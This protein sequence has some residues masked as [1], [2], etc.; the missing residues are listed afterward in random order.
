MP[1]L[2]VAGWVKR[3]PTGLIGSNKP[4]GTETAAAMIEDLPRLAP[5]PPAPKPPIDALL[6]E[7]GLR[8][9]DFAGWKR[10]DQIEVER[11]R[12]AG[13]PRVKFGRIEE[14]LA[15]LASAA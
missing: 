2:Y 10:L 5:A 9:V 11:G 7:R 3:G 1:G 13:R 12:A 4:D 15:A 14:M 8:P 6:A